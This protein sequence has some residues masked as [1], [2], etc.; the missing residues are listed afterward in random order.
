[1]WAILELTKTKRR[2]VKLQ[3]LWNLQT[4]SDKFT[5]CVFDKYTLQKTNLQTWSDKYTLCVFDKYT[6]QKNTSNLSNFKQNKKMRHCLSRIFPWDY[7]PQKMFKPQIQ[8]LFLILVW[9]C[10]E[11]RTR[12]ASTAIQGFYFYALSIL[13]YHQIIYVLYYIVNLIRT[14]HVTKIFIFSKNAS[15][16]LSVTFFSH[17]E[18][19]WYICMLWWL[20]C[21][22]EWCPFWAERRRHEARSWEDP[23]MYPPNVL[24][25]TRP[26]T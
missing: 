1:M 16:C 19:C 6:L 12:A 13:Y 5:L 25:C 21:V 9:P 15:I 10:L 20:L 18:M 7:K 23:Q 26:S 14:A 8:V 3:Q 17:F 4:W 24:K 11:S 2:N 22:F